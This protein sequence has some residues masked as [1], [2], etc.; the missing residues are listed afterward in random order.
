MDKI[1][2][3][4][5]LVIE[6]SSVSGVHVDVDVLRSALVKRKPGRPPAYTPV[7]ISEDSKTPPKKP[8]VH[9]VPPLECVKCHRKFYA[10]KGQKYC[11]RECRNSD[12]KKDFEFYLRCATCSAPL[13]RRSR[14]MTCSTS[15]RSELMRKRYCERMGIE[16]VS[17]IKY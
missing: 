15:C 5:N 1:E 6:L 16:F 9:R 4:I 11:S 14:N 17:K 3:F 8:V 12:Y 7:N 13:P 10:R 2:R